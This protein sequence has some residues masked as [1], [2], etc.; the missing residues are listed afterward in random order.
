[1]II[2]NAQVYLQT[3]VFISHTV[4]G[5]NSSILGKRKVIGRY[6]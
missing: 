4:K 3:I 5:Q 6:F 2:Y 1:M